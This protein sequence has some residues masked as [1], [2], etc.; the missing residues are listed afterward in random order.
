MNGNYFSELLKFN[1]PAQYIGFER[2]SLRKEGKNLKKFLLVSPSTYRMSADSLGGRIIYNLINRRDDACCERVFLPDP[3]RK[4]YLLESGN[5]LLSLESRLPAKSFDFVGFSFS[6]RISFLEI[7]EMFKLLDLPFEKSGS[8]PVLAA[9]GVAVGNFIPIE[10]FFDFFLVGEAEELIGKILDLYEKN[11]E[12]EIFLDKISKLAGIFVPG[13]SKKVSKA[14][15]DLRKENYPMNPVVPNIRTYQNRLDVEI[16][17][18]CP[19]N[20]RFCDARKFY[21][22]FRVL[23]PDDVFEIIKETLKNTGYGNVSLSSLST[24]QYPGILKLIDK[25]IPFLKKKGISLSIPSLRPDEKSYECVMKILELNQVN[26]TFA[27]ETFSPRL[28]KKIGK[29]TDFG[30]FEKIVAN[31]KEAGFRDFK[32]Y[33]MVG[34]PGETDEDVKETVYAVKQLGKVGMKIT[35]SVSPFVP[36]PHTSFEREKFAGAEVLKSRIL[37]IKRSLRGVRVRTPAFNFVM[38]EALLAR[39]GGEVFNAFRKMSES[40]PFLFENWARKMAEDGID[41]LKYINRDFS[42]LLDWSKIEV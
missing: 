36:L 28:Q 16:M 8:L 20:C 32:L 21:S 4:E 22:P 42:G 5:I 41:A 24:P 14:H 33:F 29:I 34:L 13:V 26:L 25:L 11:Q 27:P 1:S 31:L 23:P 2:N 30:K 10:G 39:G 35:V 18:G 17:R 6:S 15:C 12:K 3:D 19:N 37:K 7:P 9:G 40:S 38:I